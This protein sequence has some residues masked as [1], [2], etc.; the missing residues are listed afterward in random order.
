ML[1]R[2]DFQHQLRWLMYMQTHAT[3]SPS[4]ISLLYG[5]TLQIH[6]IGPHHSP[7]PQ[8]HSTDHPAN[9][10]DSSTPQIH[11]EDSQ[12]RS[13]LQIH[14]ADP[15]P[16]AAEPCLSQGRTGQGNSSMSWWMII[17]GL[18]LLGKCLQLSTV[19]CAGL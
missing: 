8:I 15:V 3:D 17:S 5:S 12:H 18:C 1:S 10:H 4:Q 7:S 19:A 9:I 2:A 6:S 13:T 16:G 14:D 11:S